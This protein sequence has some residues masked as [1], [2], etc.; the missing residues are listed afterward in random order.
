M[1]TNELLKWPSGVRNDVSVYSEEKVQRLFVALRRR[2][3]QLFRDK[4]ETNKQTKKRNKKNK[5]HTPENVVAT[6]LIQTWDYFLGC[7][8]REDCTL[9]VDQIHS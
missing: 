4:L 3:V 2:E 8:L 1:A 5:K 6:L 7:F 9:N